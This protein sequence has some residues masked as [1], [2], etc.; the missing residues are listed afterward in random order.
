MRE[1]PQEVLASLLAELAA[2]HPAV[3]RRLTRH[4]LA[5]EPARLAA[6][7]RARLQ[8]VTE[9]QRFLHRGSASHFGRELEAWLEQVERELLPLDPVRA[10]ALADAFLANDACFFEQ[11]DDSNGAIGDA[12]RAGCRLWLRAAKVQTQTDTAHWIERVYALTQADDYGAREALLA[13]ADLLFDE[14]GLRRLARRFEPDLER[15]LR[16]RE[17]GQRDY[18]L[19]KAVAAISLIA[20]VLRDPDLSTRTTLRLSP[21]PNVL[22]K[23]QIAERYLRFG[24]PQEALA[25][26]DGHWES[27]EDR[28]ERLLA[29]AHCALGDTVRLS[30]L[31]QAIFERTGS[32]ADFDAWRQSLAPAPQAHAV[33]VARQRA[34]CLDDLTAGANLLL[35][36]D[37]DAAAQALLLN[38]R[39]RVCGDAYYSLLPLAQVLE[40]KGRLL[41]AVICYRALLTSILVRGYAKAYG[42]GAEYLRVLRRLDMQIM[43]YGALD[44]HHAFEQTI[45]RAHARKS[46]FWN[47]IATEL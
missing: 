30:T 43:N 27:H 18:G 8:D 28:R 25:W 11:A 17:E 31:R 1:L 34:N 2:A 24:R 40:Q 15:A 47:R 4:T 38:R 20:D 9:P 37:D 7:F 13:H 32:P 22:Q 45:R 6:V 46:S 29:E 3:A 39:A 33:E 44:E 36:L 16:A 35:A 5:P 19:Y 26:L 41:G 23:E 42:H 10:H 21:K 14:T 12:V